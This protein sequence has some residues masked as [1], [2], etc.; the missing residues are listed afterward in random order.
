MCRSGMCLSR[1]RLCL[2][3]PRGPWAHRIAADRVTEEQGE[4]GVPIGHVA[5]GA[6][7]ERRDDVAQRRERLVDA[8]RL[9][10]P[11]PC[12]ARALL[13]LGA[14]EIDQME[15]GDALVAD[16]VVVA[17]ELGRDA[18]REDRVRA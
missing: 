17:R 15:G 13:A 7:R 3:V 4:L 18:Q 6:R 1:R 10:Q 16:A 9:T 11:R 5:G 14:C 8:A 12:G 2:G